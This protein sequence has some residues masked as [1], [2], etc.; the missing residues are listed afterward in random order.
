M[1]PIELGLDSEILGVGRA[2]RVIPAPMRRAVILRD[3][4]CQFPDAIA[5]LAGPMAITCATGST[6][7]RRSSSTWLCSAVAATDGCMREAGAWCVIQTA[8][9]DRYLPEWPISHGAG[10]PWS[11]WP[12]IR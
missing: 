9:S 7:G 5:Q 2:T 4:H 6:A 10:D 11:R 8:A 1:T 12:I 3:R